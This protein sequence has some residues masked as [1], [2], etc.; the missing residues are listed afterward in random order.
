MCARFSAPPSQSIMEFGELAL[1]TLQGA[2]LL[3]EAII[4]LHQSSNA[5]SARSVEQCNQQTL[6]V[7]YLGL[8]HRNNGSAHWIA[9]APMVL[10]CL[11]TI[12]NMALIIVCCSHSTN[13]S[14]IYSSATLLIVN[15]VHHREVPT[16]REHTSLLREGKDY[17][18][19]V[20][21][22]TN[23]LFVIKLTTHM[24]IDVIVVASGWPTW[25]E[26]RILC[27]WKD[28]HNLNI[29]R[30]CLDNQQDIVSVWYSTFRQIVFINIWSH[31]CMDQW[32]PRGQYLIRC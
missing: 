11:Q 2:I 29:Q 15:W 6:H 22:N 17:R 5:S 10:I 3:Y 7:R 30:F 13:P 18:I 23:E 4:K 8:S 9:A 28:P 19:T 25:N 20:S 32:D 31:S 1:E 26:Y 16:L 12:C 24:P 21:S 14:I 27:N